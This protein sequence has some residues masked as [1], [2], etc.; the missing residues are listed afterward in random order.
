[1][2]EDEEIT[3]NSRL[4]NN[5]DPYLTALASSKMLEQQI[6]YITNISWLFLI[7]LGCSQPFP[8]KFFLHLIIIIF[9][10]QTFHFP[11]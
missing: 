8:Y 10:A 3:G 2:G 7:L 9:S 6:N 11:S 5:E 1:M 4:H